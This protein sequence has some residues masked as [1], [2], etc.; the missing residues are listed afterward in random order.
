MVLD[1]ENTVESVYLEDMAEEANHALAEGAAWVAALR[2]YWVDLEPDDRIPLEQL[3]I[4][5]SK[6]AKR[7]K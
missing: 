2:P 3:I 1:D 4:Y 7:L 5:F 6:V